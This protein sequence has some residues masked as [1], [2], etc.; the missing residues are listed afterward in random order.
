MTTQNENKYDIAENVK[1]A[2]AQVTLPDGVEIG[3]S[4]IDETL[5]EEMAGMGSAII[6]AIFLVFL[7]MAI[8]F[9]SPKYS[10]MVMMCLPF[11]L[12]VFLD[13]CL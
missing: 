6:I 11:S 4:A 2:A 3:K 12:I 7:V 10:L 1:A 5:G 8:Q 9:N 13:C